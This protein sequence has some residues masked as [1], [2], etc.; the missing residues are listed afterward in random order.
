MLRLAE[1]LPYLVNRVGAHLVA[2]YNRELRPHGVNIQVWRVLAV[3][4]EEDGMRVSR[5][6]EV[7]SID[8][9]TLSRVLDAM[10]QKRLITRRRPTPGYGAVD[11]RMVT[12]H[13]SVRGQALTYRVLP[14]AENYERVALQGFT[15][16]EA[17]TL[18]AL[19]ARVYDNLAAGEGAP[20]RG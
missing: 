16:D 14:F 3:L 11:S 8:P 2:R 13:A 7:T 10:Q 18:K 1:Y 4:R 15:R 19:L 5:L 17:A 6:S 12:V 9:S 20:L